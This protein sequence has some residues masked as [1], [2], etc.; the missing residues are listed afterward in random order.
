MVKSTFCSSRRLVQIPVHMPVNSVSC[1]SSSRKSNAFF[2]LLDT[3]TNMAYRLKINT[4]IKISLNWGW[5]ARSLGSHTCQSTTVPPSHLTPLTFKLSKVSM[6]FLV[7]LIA[8]TLTEKIQTHLCPPHRTPT[9]NPSGS[10]LASSLGK[11]EFCVCLQS[12][13]EVLLTEA[14]ASQPESLPQ[15]G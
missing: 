8:R 1:N 5:T 14:R 9:T 12:M 7:R 4:Y 6:S 15:C 2:W 10:P 3:L 11:H 13:A